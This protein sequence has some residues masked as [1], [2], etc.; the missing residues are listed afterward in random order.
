[1]IINDVN[2]LTEPTATRVRSALALMNADTVL[3]TLGVSGV[4]VNESKR[5]LTTQMA[6]YCR[7]RFPSVADV[8]AFYS[9]AGLGGI[10]DTEARSAITWTLASKHLEGEA[11]DIVPMRNGRAWWNAPLSVWERMGALG[12]SC[13][14]RWG[15]RWKTK[16]CPHFESE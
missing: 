3:A 8:R 5:Q 1:M 14:L 13:G 11:A 16:D 6:Y 9:A 12:E 10:T 4:V 15:G 7:G 2:A